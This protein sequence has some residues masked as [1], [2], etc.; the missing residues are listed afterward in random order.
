MRMHGMPA[1]MV[2]WV[3]GVVAGAGASPRGTQGQEATTLSSGDVIEIALTVEGGRLSVPVVGRDGTEYLFALTTGNPM[4]ILAQSTADHVGGAGGLTMGGIPL[5]TEGSVTLPDAQLES[6]GIPLAGMVGG[7]TLS[8]Y[9]VLVDVPNGRL[10]LKTPG[11]AV[12]WE[13]VA[14]SEPARLQIYHGV[15]IGLQVQLDGTDYRAT[16]DLG[17]PSLIV[18]TPAGAQLGIE[19]EGMRTL[20]LGATTMDDMPVGVRDLEA[21]ERWDPA[22]TGFALIGAPIAYD[23][24]I[25]I[26][27]LHSE[28]RTCTR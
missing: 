26:S 3:V 16:L 12:A 15:V 11:R 6:D 24:A 27:W 18:N 19:G 25:S 13:G 22:G 21:F 28:L 9:D 5:A 7:S 2:W 4:T 23:C 14:L 1:G 20:T 8:A 17:T 10:L